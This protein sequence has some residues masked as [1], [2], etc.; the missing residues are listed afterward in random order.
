MAPRRTLGCL[1]IIALALCVWTACSKGSE[2]PLE[3]RCTQLANACG[4]KDKHLDKLIDECKAAAKQQ[5][6]K[7]CTDKALSA[8]DCYE[9]ELCGGDDKVWALDDFRVLSDR[10]KKCVAERNAVRDC[11]TK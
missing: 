3:K 10:H 4:A 8:Y 1:P 9:K 2:T 7:N 11:T 5:T 6:E